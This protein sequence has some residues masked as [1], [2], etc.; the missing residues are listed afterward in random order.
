VSKVIGDLSRLR[1]EFKW[2]GDMKEM[3]DVDPMNLV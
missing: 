2:P 1:N 3:L